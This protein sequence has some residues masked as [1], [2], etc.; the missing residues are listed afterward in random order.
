MSLSTTSTRLL[1]TSGDCDS[2]TS[3]G[4][5][6]QCLIT[7]SVKKFFLIS[8]LNLP[9]ETDPHLTI[10]SFQVVVESDKVSPQP[11]FLQTKQPQF[12]KPLLIKLVLHQLRCPS[13]DVNLHVFHVV[14]GPK[15]NTGDDHF[16]SPAGPTVSDISQDAIGLFGHL[17]TLSA[18]IQA[19]VNHHPQVL[20]R[21]KK[22]RSDNIDQLKNDPEQ[23]LT[24]LIYLGTTKAVGYLPQPWD[25]LSLSLHP[26]V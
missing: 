26:G 11:P 4:S 18:H 24:N 19:A 5:L 1:N 17:G 25:R 13:L 15:L 9:E 21:Q 10:T 6:F 22:I 16:P 8:S 12:P 14:R 7:L 3:L 20:F 2:T 23:V